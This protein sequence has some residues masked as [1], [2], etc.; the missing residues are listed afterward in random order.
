MFGQAYL[1]GSQRNSK[2]R[3]PLINLHRMYDIHSP[4]LGDLVVCW[5][6]PVEVLAVSYNSVMEVPLVVAV[7]RLCVCSLSYSQTV[8]LLGGNNY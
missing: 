6:L 1:D 5:E 7:N 4:C 3:T 2:L 8:D